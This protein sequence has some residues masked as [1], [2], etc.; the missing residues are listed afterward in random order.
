MAARKITK[1]GLTLR[2]NSAAANPAIRKC[3]Q[4]FNVDLPNVSVALATIATMIAWSPLKAESTTAG[5]EYS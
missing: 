3:F 2:P 4:V 1:T 5:Y